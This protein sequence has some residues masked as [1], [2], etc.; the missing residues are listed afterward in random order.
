MKGLPV[1]EHPSEAIAAALS[2]IEKDE[3]AMLDR[4]LALIRAYDGA[5]YGFDLLVNAAMNRS[6]AVST[7]FRTLI[8]DR[9]MI[10]AGTLLRLQLDTA[11]RL[12]AGFIVEDPHDFALE[13]LKGA[14]IRRLKDQTGEFMTDRYLV[15]QLEEK[16][17]GVKSVYEKTS[18]Y[19]HLSD[20]HIS[21][22][23]DGANREKGAIGIKISASDKQYPDTVYLDAI[24]AF[25]SVTL[26][27][28]SYVDGWHYTKTNPEKVAAMK[29]EREKQ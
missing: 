14:H 27:L 6:L 10:C 7:G 5:V 11:L 29:A 8:R 21:S 23:F 15:T 20:V 25:R 1:P 19:V 17:P 18:A 28:S 4:A 24:S 16:Y 12:F 22:T 2:D 3:T 9:N 13:V 26:I